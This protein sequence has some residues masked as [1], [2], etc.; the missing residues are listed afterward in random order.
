M[1]TFFYGGTGT[2][3]SYAMM[4]KIKQAAENGRKV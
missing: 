3:K 4:D 2:G 1:L